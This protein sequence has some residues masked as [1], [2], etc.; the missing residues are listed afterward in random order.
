MKPPAVM[1]CAPMN[2]QLNDYTLRRHSSGAM[3]SPGPRSRCICTPARTAC[4]VPPVVT[5][6]WLL[7][8]R[9][10]WRRAGASVQFPTSNPSPSLGRS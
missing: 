2:L 8:R 7:W 6:M 4:Q 10:G 1:V 3:E 5:V 9:A